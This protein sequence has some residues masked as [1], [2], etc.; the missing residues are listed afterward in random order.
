MTFGAAASGWAT[1]CLVVLVCGILALG[2]LTTGRS[3]SLLAGSEEF[4]L[5]C[6]G[7]VQV[8]DMSG[9]SIYSYECKWGRWLYISSAP[10]TKIW[11]ALLVP[12][13][14]LQ[15]WIRLEYLCLPVNH[16]RQSAAGSMYRLLG[17]TNYHGWN[18][19]YC[20]RNLSRFTTWKTLCCTHV[21]A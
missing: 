7:L 4:F 10:L 21:G 16:V 5:D 18:L 1:V 11:R 2:R 20:C 17:R 8:V 3:G 14:D 6:E 12:T 15:S 9:G 13:R 19:I